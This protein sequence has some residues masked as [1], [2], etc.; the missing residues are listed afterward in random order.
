MSNDKP[1]DNENRHVTIEGTSF[2]SLSK[3]YRS[4]FKT[5]KD[6]DEETK[7]RMKSAKKRA[8]ELN[9]HLYRLSG[10][11]TD[12]R[13]KSGATAEMKEEEKKEIPK[14]T[15]LRLNKDN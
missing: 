12:S 11:L 9:G 4:E 6:A 15:W 7:K 3:F 2:E 13:T 5:E 1:G 10:Y 14:D 8:M